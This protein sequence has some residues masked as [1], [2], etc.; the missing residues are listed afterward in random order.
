MRNTYA[1][2]NISLHEVLHG[3][4]R[5]H[6]HLAR[7]DG[8]NIS[9]RGWSYNDLVNGVISIGRHE[10]AAFAQTAGIETL[11]DTLDAMTEIRV[12][13]VHYLR[14]MSPYD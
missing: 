7:R 12:N 3:A 14:A 11:F 1:E 13:A 9:T 8:E 5:L 2:T 4:A 10:C 6:V